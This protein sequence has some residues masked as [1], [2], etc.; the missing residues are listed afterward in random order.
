MQ[1]QDYLPFFQDLLLH[2]YQFT[3]ENSVYASCLAIAVWLLTA[4]F[5]SFR[6]GFLNRRNNIMLKARLDLQNELAAAQQQIQALQEE[7]TTNKQQIEQEAE[8]TEALQERISGLGSQLAE[9]IVALAA[10]PDLGQQGLS[11]SPGLEAEHLWQRYSS[12]VKQVGE[13]LITQRKTNAELQQAISAET[14]KLAEKDQ[15]LQATQTRFDLQKQQL[16]KLELTVEEH[17][18][19][20]AQQQESAQQRLSEAEAKHLAD[21][22]RLTALEQQ[23]QKTAQT[24]PLQ[25]AAKTQEPSIVR[26]ET[27][28]PVEVKPAPVQTDSAQQQAQAVKVEP[29]PAMN[30]VIAAEP[31]VAKAEPPKQQPAKAEKPASGGFAGKFKTLFADAKQ[32]MEK[33]DGKLGVSNPQLPIE[34]AGQV[35]S[36]PQARIEEAPVSAQEAPSH[37]AQPEVAVKSSS[38]GLG[39]KFKN[40]FGSSKT[41]PR[42]DEAPVEAVAAESEPQPAETTADQSTD[43]GAASGK[44]KG[45]FGKLKRK[46]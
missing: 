12:A 5:Y 36:E 17:K 39:G 8:R 19:E 42:V 11:V 18:A 32:K 15:Q 2:Y 27:A 34:E 13:G 41:A 21:L 35:E 37:Q 20:L 30:E 31:A 4:I 45:L 9:S 44:L 38:G 46:A 1:V 7:I 43:K 10:D 3:L 40:M 25:E 23:A 33:L 28:K 14:A 24:R 29:K 6:I 16:A 22:A 26:M